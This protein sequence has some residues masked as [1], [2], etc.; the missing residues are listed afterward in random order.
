MNLNT[1]N[2][3]AFFTKKAYSLS[4]FL[5]LQV[6][7]SE[8][9]AIDNATNEASRD[10]FSPSQEILTKTTSPYTDNN[11]PTFIRSGQVAKMPQLSLRGVVSS[12]K[13][14]SLVALLELQGN[15]KQ[16]HMVKIGDEIA[17]DYRDPSLVLKIR[18]INRL[19]LIVE[20]GSLGDVI[21]VR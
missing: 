1:P 15:D 14:N 6:F 11:R 8:L 7:S 20:V 5:L 9:L 17:F 16:L 2:A 3:N 10:P 18:E 21:I 4:F 19:S 12:G 13:E